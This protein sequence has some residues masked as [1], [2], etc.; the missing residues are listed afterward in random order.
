MNV[1]NTAD[2]V[3][4]QTRS[5]FYFAQNLSMQKLTALFSFLV[6]SI[7]A[8]AQT[9]KINVCIIDQKQLKTVVADYDPATGDTTITVNGNKRAFRQIYKA[10]GTEYAANTTWYVNNDALIIRSRKFVKYGLPRILGTN[11]IT[12]AAEYKGVGVY[13]EAGIKGI[14]QVIY[15]PVR[16]GC[17]FQPYQ[18]EKKN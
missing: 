14:P 3:F 2:I 17:E 13:I 10:T 8:L 1:L 5:R 11:E 9:Q 12:R 16:S 18:M 6:I 7:S 4:A 15:I